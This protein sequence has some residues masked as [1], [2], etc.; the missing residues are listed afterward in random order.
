MG[1]LIVEDQIT[2]AKQ[3]PYGRD[4][5]GMAADIDDA[6]FRAHELGYGFLEEVMGRAFAA[7][8]P[9][10]ACRSA[11]DPG[12]FC[13]R[14]RDFG[15]RIDIEV[16]IC[17]KVDVVFSID[18]DSGL[19]CAVGAEEKRIGHTLFGAHGHHSVERKLRA[20]LGEGA[21]RFLFLLSTL[22][23]FRRAGRHVHAGCIL[24]VIEIRPF[25]LEVCFHQ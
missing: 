12:C 8:E 25:G 9:A 4:V 16:V 22:M 1:K 19:R 24:D 6:V 13:Y 17:G 5:G 20:K 14:S 21:Y 3:E 23:R 15:M 2:G 18:M 10:G 7:H 11:E